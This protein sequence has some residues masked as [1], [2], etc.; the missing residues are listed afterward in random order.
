[1]KA[2][3]FHRRRSARKPG[4]RSYSEFLILPDGK[5]FAHN[6]T[7]KMARLLAQLDPSDEAMRRRAAPHRI[8]RHEFFN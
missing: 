6:I 2:T 3:G 5:I 4:K 7:K 8:S 1:V